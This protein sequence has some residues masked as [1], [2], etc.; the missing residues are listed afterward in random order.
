M[1]GDG[2]VGQPFDKALAID[3]NDYFASTYK[4]F[5]LLYL[6]NCTQ[7]YTYLDKVSVYP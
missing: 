2:G 6:G 3:P 1:D 5:A 4:G 7:A